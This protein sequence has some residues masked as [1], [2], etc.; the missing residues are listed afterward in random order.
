ML[1]DP[2]FNLHGTVYQLLLGQLINDEIA[3][4]RQ[5]TAGCQPTDHVVLFGRCIG[6]H[7]EKFLLILLRKLDNNIIRLHH[8][9][10][11]TVNFIRRLPEIFLIVKHLNVLHMVPGVGLYLDFKFIGWIAEV[12]F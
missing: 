9:P 10:V 11:A 5:I 12:F 7:E 2:G 8:L 4:V 3:V 1:I 6:K